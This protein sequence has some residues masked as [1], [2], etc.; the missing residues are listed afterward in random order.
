MFGK[1]VWVVF[2]AVVGVGLTF[3]LFDSAFAGRLIARFEREPEIS[4]PKIGENLTSQD[5]LT[6]GIAVLPPFFVRRSNA[7]YRFAVF[8][9]NLSTEGRSL[10]GKQAVE[11]L[12]ALGYAVMTSAE[13]RKRLIE[14]SESE[15]TD[16][17]IQRVAD[18]DTYPGSLAATLSRPDWIGESKRSIHWRERAART[19]GE[20]LGV[21]YFLKSVMV[22][23]KV[24]DGIEL[25]IYFGLFDAQ[26][27]EV[28]LY[29]VGRGTGKEGEER[30]LIKMACESGL[31]VALKEVVAK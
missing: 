21:G 18:F 8:E 14:A 29:V 26:T 10:A 25:T 6:K 4:V 27:G 9:G 17:L 15:S 2:L 23:R 5:L 1:K 3:F 31:N 11:S 28:V 12:S 22:S 24:E 30:D 20:Y 13:A 19:L 7:P 16:P